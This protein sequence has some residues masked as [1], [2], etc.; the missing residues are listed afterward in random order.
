VKTGTVFES[1]PVPPDTVAV[2][3]APGVRGPAALPEFYGAYAS[4]ILLGMAKR[5]VL[6]AA[7]FDL[8]TGRFTS[9]TGEIEL[10]GSRKTLKTVTPKSEGFVLEAGD[11]LRG[12]FASVEKASTFCAVLAASHDGRPLRESGRILI[13]HLTDVK[14]LNMKFLDRGMSVV[15]DWGEPGLLMR[16][17]SVEIRLAAELAMTLYACAPDGTRLFRVGT[18]P[19]PGGIRFVADNAARGRAVCVYELVR[20]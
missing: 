10:V 11:S 20:E 15:G 7:L 1:E 5:G 2:V 19:I 14:G 4:D 18:E 3:A 13:L 6:P 16:R 12:D 17:G 9:S 8:K